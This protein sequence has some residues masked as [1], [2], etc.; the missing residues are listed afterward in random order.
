[1]LYCPGRQQLNAAL[2]IMT[3]R[4]ASIRAKLTDAELA[5]LKQ[6]FG[7]ELRDTAGATHFSQIDD[8]RAQLLIAQESLRRLSPQGQEEGPPC[9]F[10]N[11][12][13]SAVGPLAL[14][15]Y[16]SYI[17]RACATACLELFQKEA[18]DA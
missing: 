16:G 2:G 10:C 4:L 9:S 15:A 11:A 6:V 7:L 3:V 17:C 1:V 12:A 5:Y 14:S 18:H 13:S 8:A